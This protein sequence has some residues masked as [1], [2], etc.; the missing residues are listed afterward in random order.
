MFQFKVDTSGLER[1]AG[2]LEATRA[3]LPRAIAQGLNQGG[4]RVRTVVQRTL[5][6]QTS[7]TL[8]RSITSRMRTAR[9]FEGSLA[10]QIIATGKGIP[11]KEFPVEVVQGGVE[12]E[13]WGAEHLFKRSF[14][15]RYLGGLRARIGT[16]RFPVR[17]LYG[18]ALPKEL[19]QGATPAAF[20]GA[21][22][23]FVPP[24]LLRA[25]GRVLV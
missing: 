8:Y 19:G 2:R 10:Y 16:G 7:V 23:E 4:D 12:A 14:R 20:A 17:S 21:A 3:R 9:A 18:P 15:Q 1:M 22:A 25:L 24:A 11:I 6:E 5:K 13:T